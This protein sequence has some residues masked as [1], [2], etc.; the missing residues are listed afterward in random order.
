[1][2]LFL[3][4][5][6]FG[7]HYPRFAELAGPP[8]PVAVIANACDAQPAKWRDSGVQIEM[9]ALAKLGYRPSE[10]DLREFVGRADDVAEALSA[11]P[12]V[13]VRGGNTFVLRAQLARSGADAALTALLER[14]AL[15]YAG[16]SAGACVA[17][18]SLRGIE[19]LDDPDEVLPACGIDTRWDGLG[20]V[21]RG[22]VVHLDSPATDPYGDAA[23]L[24]ARYRAA[25]T[26]YWPLTDADAVL[27][28]GGD[29]QVLAAARS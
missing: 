28:R 6:R 21:D 15:L 24:V 10:L 14:D 19:V 29:I 11:F 1:M 5:Y 20:W 27:V 7:E 13:W 9:T 25:G 16:F 22:L 12:V 2:R 3:S 26:P 8:G 18:P 17:A 4:S 23:R